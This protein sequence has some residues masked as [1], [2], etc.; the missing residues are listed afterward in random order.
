MWEDIPSGWFIKG[1][2]EL[3]FVHCKVDSCRRWE[4]FG[5]QLAD[6]ESYCEDDLTVLLN[7]PSLVRAETP[8]P[9]HSLMMKH[10]SA[11]TKWEASKRHPKVLAKLKPCFF[12]LIYKSTGHQQGAT[13]SVCHRIPSVSVSPWKAPLLLFCLGGS[14]LWNICICVPMKGPSAALLPWWIISMKHL[15]VSPWKAPLLSWWI[16]SMKHLYVSPWKAPLLLFC[17]G[18]SSLC[19][20]CICVPMKG[21]SAALLPWWIISM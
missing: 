4:W 7:A 11:S 12:C 8:Q 15:Y 17:L 1:S 14:S 5:W 18:G 3:W 19:N 2:R 21:P 16:I 10:R 9:T 6:W 20:V 13:I